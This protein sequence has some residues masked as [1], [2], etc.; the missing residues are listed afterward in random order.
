MA[1]SIFPLLITSSFIPSLWSLPTTTLTQQ[2][3]DLNYVKFPIAQGSQTFPSNLTVSGI[4]SLGGLTMSGSN[5]ITLGSGA[6]APVAGQLGYIYS[7]TT[8]ATVLSTVS[9][10]LTITNLPIGV[11]ILNGIID[12]GGSSANNMMKLNLVATSTILTSF[13]GPSLTGVSVGGASGSF[14]Y[15]NT[16]V[17]DISLSA[18]TNNASNTTSSIIFLQAIR[19]A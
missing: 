10:F 8:T 18:E 3:A 5:N 15:N 7:T 2:Y 9:T 17:Q 12:G 1:S 11:Y 13:W 16:I 4:T 19:I 14:F 6:T